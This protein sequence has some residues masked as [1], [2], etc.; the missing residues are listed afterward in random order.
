MLAPIG[1]AGASGNVEIVEMDLLNR[2]LL[3]KKLP[4]PTPITLLVPRSRLTRLV[5]RLSFFR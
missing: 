2:Q 4:E 3:L 1:L 5:A